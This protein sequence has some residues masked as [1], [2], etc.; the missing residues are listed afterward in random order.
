MSNA[1]PRHPGHLS[2]Q[3]LV[4]F[5][6]VLPMLMILIM[7]I[8]EFGRLML[9]ISSVSSGS[10]EAARYGASAGD[11]SSGIAHYQDCDG[12]R[13]AARNVS[14]FSDPVIYIEYDV[15]GP[16]GAYPVP[17][18]PNGTPSDPVRIPLG[19]QI[20][21]KVT[22]DYQP[23]VPLFDLKPMPIHSEA[24]RTILKDVYVK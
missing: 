20:V 18:C 4:E 6:L 23:L 1:D 10:R 13:N 2:G 14:L 9:T 24:K 7:G 12:M 22:A 16:D 11:N 21:I 8:I 15:D 17:Y 3:G 5:A 19:T